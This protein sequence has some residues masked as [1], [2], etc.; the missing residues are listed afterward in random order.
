MVSKS[1]LQL[2]HIDKIIKCRIKKI[3]NLELEVKVIQDKLRFFKEYYRSMFG[4]YYFIIY[5]F[6][7]LNLIFG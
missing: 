1:C 5:L 3:V 7:F 2:S 4:S 6:Y